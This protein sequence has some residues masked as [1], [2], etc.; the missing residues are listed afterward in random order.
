MQM[1]TMLASAPLCETRRSAPPR[2]AF[3]IICTRSISGSQSHVLLLTDIAS[4][5]NLQ[6]PPV[7]DLL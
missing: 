4:Y 7:L 1:Y 5:R 2:A 6:S 3:P